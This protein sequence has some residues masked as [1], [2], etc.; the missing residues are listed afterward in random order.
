[1]LNNNPR[2]YEKLRQGKLQLFRLSWVGDYPDAE[3]FLQLFYSKN[4]GGCNRVGFSDPEYDRMFEGDPADA[5]SPE[6]TERYREMVRYLGTKWSD[7]FEGFPIAYQLNH[8]W[9]ENYHPHDFAFARLEI[10]DGGPGA[11]P[12]AQG[13]LHAAQHARTQSVNRGLPARLPPLENPSVGKF[14]PPVFRIESFARQP[15]AVQ[16]EMT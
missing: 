8:A 1:M 6:R 10:P 5:G 2:F 16:L 12:A 14:R 4:I 11:P 7:G 15:V 13:H 3:N 9:L